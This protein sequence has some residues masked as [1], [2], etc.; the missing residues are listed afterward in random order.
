MIRKSRC[1]KFPLYISPGV[2]TSIGKP[3][4]RHEI[5]RKRIEQSQ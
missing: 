3:I 2:P 1:F 5:E 4:G